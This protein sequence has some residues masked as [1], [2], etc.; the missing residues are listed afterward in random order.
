MRI[1]WKRQ[2]GSRKGVQILTLC[3][4]VNTPNTPRELRRKPVTIAGIAESEIENPD[5]RRLFWADVN[6]R[7][8]LHVQDESERKQIESKIQSKVPRP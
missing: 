8:K 6:T 1:L 7:L 3:L 5:M 2:S 4:S